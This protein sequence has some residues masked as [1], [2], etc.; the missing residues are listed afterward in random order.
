M[1]STTDSLPTCPGC[2][3][4]YGGRWTGHEIQGVYDGTLYWSCGACGLAWSRNWTGYGRRGEIAQR[5]VDEHNA[6]RAQ[7][8]QDT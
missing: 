1:T 2:G 4:P 6:R 3:E 7:G 8:H 5:Y